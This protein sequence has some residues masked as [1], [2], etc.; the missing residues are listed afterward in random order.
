M[1]PP[2]PIR[3]CVF[4]VAG[5]GTRLLPA[6]KVC[7]KEMLTLV[8][9]PLIQHAVD[10][11]TAAGIEE[12]IFVTAPHK[13]MLEDH[14]MPFDELED[15]LERRGKTDMLNAVRACNLPAGSLMTVHQPKAL[16]LGHAVW[17]ARDL[18]G[19]EPF[20]VILPDDVFLPGPTNQPCL[21]QLVDAH[22]KIGGAMCAWWWMCRA[23]KPGGTALFNPVPILGITSKSPAWLKN[24]I[25]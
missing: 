13:G 12:F 4:P 25:Q 9:R 24:P 5:L 14:F 3:K 7:P 21:A 10:E 6:T 15:T 18:V 16:G 8:D 22:K 23:I 11:A 17:C 2:K 19:D 1:T 20:A